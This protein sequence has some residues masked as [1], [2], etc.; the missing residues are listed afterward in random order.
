MWLP[1]SLM[2]YFTYAYIKFEQKKKMLIWLFALS[3]LLF[4][5]SYG[6]QNALHHDLIFRN[7]KY[8]PNIYYFTFGTSVILAFSLF[9][10]SVLQSKAVMTVFHFFSRFS[11]SIYFI[12]YTVLTV[13]VVFIK[14]LHFNWLTLF[15]SVLAITVALQKIFIWTRIKLHS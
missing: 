11:Y 8:P 15:L 4:A 9:A 10:K 1:W 13:L 5:V 6:I 2:F 3:V 14:E 12:H 7:N